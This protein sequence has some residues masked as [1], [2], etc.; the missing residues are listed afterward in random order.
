MER[1]VCGAF[2]AAYSA[3]PS[4]SPDRDLLVLDVYAVEQLVRS[5]LLTDWFVWTIDDDDDDDDDDDM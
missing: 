5:E 3:S 2:E 1:V 4:S